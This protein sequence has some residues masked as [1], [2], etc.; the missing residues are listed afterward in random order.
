MKNKRDTM[1]IETRV[2]LREVMRYHPTTID[3]KATVAKAAATMCHD[4]VGS[5]IVLQN[6][7]PTGIITEQDIN[8]K[9]VAKDIKPGSITVSEVMSTPLI[10]ISAD[11]TVGDAGQMMVKHHVRRLP[12]VDGTQVVGIVTVR[13]ILSVASEINEIMTELMAINREDLVEMGICDRCHTMSDDLRR[14]DNLMLC[15][16]CRE[17][18]NLV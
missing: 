9:V 11:K 4:E 10:T 1:Q 2:S 8:C 7:I 16:T 13:D 6:N 3:S 18:D 15:S 5:C 12:V 14:I 17:E